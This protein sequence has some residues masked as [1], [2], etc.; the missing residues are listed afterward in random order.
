LNTLLQDLRYAFRQLSANRG[1]ALLAI[2][3]LALGIGVNTAMFTVTDSVLLRPLPYRDAERLVDVSGSKEGPGNATSWL[4]YRDIQEH[5]G[6]LEEVAGYAE[7]VGVVETAQATQSVFVPRVTPNLFYM[8]GVPA[9][10]GRGLTEADAQPGADPVAVLSS[11][12]WKQTFA[13]D[14]QVLGRQV[15]I[16]GVSRRI[17]GVMPDTFRF[18]AVAP[19]QTN[20]VWLPLQ[21]TPEMLQERGF[22]FMRVLGK[23]RAGVSF[24]A[25]QAELDALAEHIRGLDSAGRELPSFLLSSY[26]N[27]LTGSVQPVFLALTVALILVLLIACANVANLQLSRFLV[28][29]QELAVRAALGANRLQLARQL[30]CEGGLLSLLS[31]ALG[32]FLA[33]LMLQMIQRLPAGLLPRS[34]EIHL[35][36]GILLVLLFIAAACTV[37]SSLIPA[38]LSARVDPQPALQAASRALGSKGSH[39][40][41]SRWLI[42]GEVSLSVV[43]LIATGLVF[44]TLWNLEH[45]CFGFLTEGITTFNAMPADAVGVS[46]IT[47]SDELEHRPTSLAIQIYA[48]LLTELKRLPAVE[49]TA[50]ATA[51]PFDGGID[52]RAKFKVLGRG[53][54]QQKGNRT[55]VNVV[56]AR[57]SQIMGIA[58]LHGRTILDGDGPQQPFVAVVNR[59]FVK[60][61]FPHDD[62]LGHQLDF[63]K[64][65][66][67]AKP[68]TIIGVLANT[69]QTNV[70]SPIEPEVYLPFL[71]IP[72]ASLFYSALLKTSVSFVIRASNSADVP[73][74][75]RRV[76]QRC[77]PGYAV[78]H[79]QAM[80]QTIKQANSSQEAGFYLIGS[81]A[82]LAVCMVVAGMYG[83]L[84]QLISHR[85]REIALRMAVGATRTSVLVMILRQS[86]VL[87]AGGLITGVALALALGR[88]LR[89]FL[90][91]VSP[92]DV[93]TYLAVAGG[94]FAIGCAA[95]F[96]PARQAAS[97]EPIQALRAE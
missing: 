12:F 89:G 75:V 38:W 88:L 63:G 71:Q 45:G 37:L 2:V 54:Q 46:G 50:L 16:S 68:Y 52:L 58:L 55:R 48:P 41:L 13:G 85:Q 90:F 39:S 74:S 9:V 59:S 56:S 72:P 14:P 44:R 49:G 62:P 32:L 24:R 27:S 19:D 86:S 15:R 64:K 4:N 18:M 51:L 60:K 79:F 82:A 33:W 80:R 3:T 10:L 92:V 47:L 7:D 96:F 42:A 17:V 91:G 57:Y 94:L 65:N 34:H 93:P 30:T 53:E 95:S 66:G 29:Q 5:C 28:R 84:T 31:A 22:R 87:I 36:W 81:F 78:E 35:R 26:A 70:N 61:Y 23:V 67:M 21:P 20:A 97:I 76:F 43:L 8:L 6:Q 83:V 1:F 40:R 69:T 25:A 77:A 73:S 11:A